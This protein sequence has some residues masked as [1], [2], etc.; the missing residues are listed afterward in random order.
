MV[1]VAACRSQV[2][3]N[4]NKPKK[5]EAWPS[6]KTIFFQV[7]GMCLVCFIFGDGFVAFGLGIVSLFCWSPVYDLLL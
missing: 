7:G 2:A 6:L 3:K 5:Y 1:M 4:I